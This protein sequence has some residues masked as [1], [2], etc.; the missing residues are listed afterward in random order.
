[1][2]E[3]ATELRW[4]DPICTIP[5]ERLLLSEKVGYDAVFTAEGYGNEGIVPLGY[6]AA[7]PSDS[8]SERASRR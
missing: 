5:M 2:I 6:I 4:Q 8:S 3:L 7:A 1:M